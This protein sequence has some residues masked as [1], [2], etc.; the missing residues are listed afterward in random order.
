MKTTALFAKALILTDKEH[1]VIIFETEGS[2]KKEEPAMLGEIRLSNSIRFMSEM[3][4]VRLKKVLISISK[5]VTETY[6]I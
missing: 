3:Q 5:Y 6:I 4:K 1:L 2:E